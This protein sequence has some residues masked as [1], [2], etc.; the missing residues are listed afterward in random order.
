MGK[1][2]TGEK[3]KH[4]RFVRGLLLAWSMLV[5]VVDHVL[6][7]P[8]RDGRLR[9]KA[10]P[11]GLR[12]IAVIAI[13]GYALA[14]LG[15]VFSG[16]LRESLELSVTVGS[17][18]LSFPRPVLWVVL[19]LVVLAMALLQTA[20]IHVPWWLATAVTT[21]TVLSLLFAG[22]LDNEGPLSPGRL[23]TILAG[24][25]IIVFTIVR[26]GRRFA[27]WEFAVLLPTIG[28]ALAIATGGAA[29]QSAPSG[30]DFGPIVLSLTMSTLGQ[31]A[32][33]AAIA[34]GAAVAELSASTA[35][36]VVGVVRRRLPAIAIIIGLGLVIVW[37]VWAIVA[38][39]M[40]EDGI[41]VVQ[42]A[43]SALLVA[44]IAGL[45]V[46]LAG[47]RNRRR[48]VPSALRLVARMG[49]VATPIGAG[50][51]VTLGPLVIFLL[52]TQILFSYGVPL[53]SVVLL[54]SAIAVLT[55][56]SAITFVRFAV[57][58]ALVILAFV[59]ARRGS[60]TVP[61]LIGG[62][63]IV[64]IT[65]ALAGFFGLGDWLWTSSGLTAVATVG[66]F[67]LLVWFAVRRSLTVTRVTGLAVALLLAA[68]FDQRDFVS[69]PLGA[70]LGFTG[71]A[72]VLFGFVWSFLTG[73]ASANSTSTAY[74][75]PA[76]VL[77]F[78]ANSVFGVTVLA[79][80]AL[81]R[82]PNASINLGGFAKIGDQ[83]F[84]T[85]L[86]V[87]AL[88]AVVAAV[89]SDTMPALESPRRKPAEKAD[90]V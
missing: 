14:V 37:R 31:L 66:C 71:V 33:P 17:A 41:G 29:A 28:V 84:G 62:I 56:S 85:G 4:S 74:P 8:Y 32:V 11:T 47:V 22:G 5:E 65:V 13:G 23:A 87:G 39:F 86:L 67:G 16:A 58:V 46:L 78:L 48:I 54:Q 40:S 60:R 53:E 79:F 89:I 24:L 25:G 21:L 90:A 1:E 3:P 83:L 12:T 68:F 82:D 36:W 26:R 10:W 49:S 30:F 43:S 9:A 27:W 73:G 70:I 15:I 52:A 42:L 6:A 63:G 20:A 61:E 75:R 59:L 2:A 55:T 38:V 77:L 80:N 72:F 18:T 44:A 64:T 88:L 81:A 7:D 51:A 19:F 57:G 35:L 34:A 45:W 50:L 69:D 76:R